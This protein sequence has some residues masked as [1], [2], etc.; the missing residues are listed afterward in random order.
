MRRF[1]V[2]AGILVATAAAVWVAQR[3]PPS[4]PEYGV[5]GVSPV[6][7]KLGQPSN[8]APADA[9]T[10]STTADRQNIAKITAAFTAPIAFYGK[11]VDQTGA[12]VA[13]AKVYYSAADQ[14]FGKSTKRQGLSDA[15]GRFSAEGLRGAG[16]YVEVSKDGYDRI[17]DQ[18]YSSFGYG[19]GTAKPP[20]TKDNPALFVL[21]KKGSA[22]A[23]ITSDADVIVAKNG[24]PTDL[25]LRTGKAV[26]V[27]GG[28]IT[29][30][31]WTHDEAPD[32]NGHY[33]W[34]C[35]LSVPGGGLLRREDADLSFDA[36]VEGYQPSVDFDMAHAAEHW[37]PDQQG[38]YWVKLHDNTYG[39]MKFRITTAGGHF[40]SVTS[41]LNPS[42]SR[43][44]EFDPK[45]AIRK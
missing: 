40:A 13:N 8:T 17:P 2:I 9:T 24:A 10:S 25:S 42:G 1:I 26:T 45:K 16:L 37:R 27:G 21:R 5:V 35:R 7:N 29:V 19:V 11:V 22:D 15:E 33:D 31:C 36:P 3:H 44:L 30:E 23:L 12:A 38:E 18:S 28:D 32:A 20:P 6:E 43:N 14:Y 34:R 4:G 39:R 41:F